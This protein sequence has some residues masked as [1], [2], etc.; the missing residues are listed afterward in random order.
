MIVEANIPEEFAKDAK[1]GSRVEIVPVADGSK[2][3][4]GTVSRISSL[5]VKSSGET[6][7]PVEIVIVGTDG[8]LLPNFNVDVK[9]Y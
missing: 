6:V 3:Y 8:F 2:T 4:A 5:A 9:I 1:V 7:I